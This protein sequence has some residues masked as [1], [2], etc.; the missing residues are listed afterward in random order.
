MAITTVTNAAPKARVLMLI[1][2]VSKIKIVAANGTLYT[3]VNPAPEAQAK[4]N[5]ASISLSPIRRTH[6]LPKATEISCGATSRPKG[7][8]SPTVII[9]NSA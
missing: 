5:L 7:E 8:P 2:I 1:T 4:I 9:C 3:A 6:T